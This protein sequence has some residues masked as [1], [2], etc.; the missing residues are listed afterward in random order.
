MREWYRMNLNINNIL[1][2]I[3]ARRYGWNV[4]DYIKGEGEVQDMLR[5]DNTA[6]FGLSHELDY[7]GELVRIAEQ[8]DPV[9]KEKMIDALKWVW[10]DERTF[11]DPFSIEA[12]FAYMCKLEI[13]YRWADLDVEKG[14]ESFHRIIENLRGEARV[15]DEFRKQ[16][17]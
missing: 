15:P 8:T 11:M 7:A 9:R 16:G 14:K 2:A 17:R 4:S 12:V 6:D 13:Q 10:L 1:S 3:L 5:E